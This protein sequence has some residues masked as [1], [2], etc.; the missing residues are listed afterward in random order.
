M[1]DYS[2]LLELAEIMANEI[3]AQS[4]NGWGNTVDDLAAAIRDLQSQL[5]ALQARVDMKFQPGDF[6][7]KTGGSY[8]LDGQ[9]MVGFLTAKRDPRYV[10]DHFPMAPGLLHI[11][12]ESQ[13]R[14]LT[15]KGEG[16]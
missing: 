1:T 4:I 15:R 5:A 11:Y 3:R 8:E 16:E 10:V 9:V 2:K 13:L 7:L 6:V 12:N 14:A